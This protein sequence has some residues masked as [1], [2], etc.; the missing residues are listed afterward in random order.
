MTTEVRPISM[1]EV[2]GY[3]QAFESVARERR[4]GLRP[5]PWPRWKRGFGPVSS[6]VCRSL[7]PSMTSGWSAG[8]IFSPI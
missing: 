3:H 5:R 6:R 2:A 1:E 4:S 8:A 7:W